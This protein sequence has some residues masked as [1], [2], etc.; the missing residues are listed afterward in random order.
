MIWLSIGQHTLWFIIIEN[1]LNYNT[2][3]KYFYYHFI[4]FLL[5]FVYDISNKFQKQKT[6]H[7]EGQ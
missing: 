6:R 3:I 4:F 2:Y 7:L 1:M 5:Q